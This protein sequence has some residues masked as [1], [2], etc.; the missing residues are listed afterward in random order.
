MYDPR[1]SDALVLQRPPADHPLRT[2]QLV[3]VV[4]DPYVG[5]HLRQALF[6]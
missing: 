1:R 3:D 6:S 5:R 2:A 4:L